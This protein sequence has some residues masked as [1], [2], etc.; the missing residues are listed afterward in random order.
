M[1]LSVETFFQS[2]GAIAL[3]LL[4]PGAGSAA[5]PAPCHAAM[6]GTG[7][8]PAPAF[9]VRKIRNGLHILERAE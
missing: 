7:G 5:E 6:D 9:I 3:A 8:D 4:T 1:I 2:S